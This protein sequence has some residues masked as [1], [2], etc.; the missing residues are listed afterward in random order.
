MATFRPIG[1]NA[2][3]WAEK[4][5]ELEGDISATHPRNRRRAIAPENKLT[6]MESRWAEFSNV[7]FGGQSP[8]ETIRNANVVDFKIFWEWHFGKSNIGALSTLET[9]WKYLR[10]YYTCELGE[11]M[12]KNMSTSSV[13]NHHH[14]ACGL[15]LHVLLLSF[16]AGRP[17]VVLDIMC[18]PG[19]AL[20]YKTFQIV[21]IHNENGQRLYTIKISYHLVKAYQPPTTLVDTQAAFM[22]QDS[23]QGLKDKLLPSGLLRD[24]NAPLLLSAVDKEIIQAL[25][26]YSTAE[27]SVT[28]MR[29]MLKTK[30]GRKYVENACGGERANYK[31][32]KSNVTNVRRSLKKEKLDTMIKEY[33]ANVCNDEIQ[34]QFDKGT[35]K[36]VEKVELDILLVLATW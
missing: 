17:G 19:E 18:H 21:A 7:M 27:K 25:P 11:S 36:A 1:R 26:E 5:K 32:V 12:A 15:A 3:A 34:W 33:F 28:E 31:R 20:K 13:I 10:L 6:T 30:Y 22:R 24:P 2:S 35:K 8:K 4:R 9:S 29:I 16:T 23:R 14:K